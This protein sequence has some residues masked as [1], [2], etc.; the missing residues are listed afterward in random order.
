[1]ILSFLTGKTFKYIALA[2]AIAIAGIYVYTTVQS[3]GQLKADNAKLEFANQVSTETIEELQKNAAR[4]RE[5]NGELNRR[6][7]SAA[8]DLSRFREEV[9]NLKLQDRALVDPN[10]VEEN[11]NETVNKLF[12]D[13][14]AI[15]RGE[16]LQ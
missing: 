5:L 1:M 8:S 12:D 15:S 11:L 6:L 16:R 7:Q 14:N 2:G 4:Q 3:I 10:N 13:L 9:R